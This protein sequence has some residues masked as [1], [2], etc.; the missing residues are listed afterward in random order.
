[1]IHKNANC[2]IHA[3]VLTCNQDDKHRVNNTTK[4]RPKKKRN[5]CYLFASDP[6][7]TI[8]SKE[9]RHV[10][11]LYDSI[12][13]I[14]GRQRKKR[15]MGHHVSKTRLGG[16]V[17]VSDRPT[18]HTWK[19]LDISCVYC[20]TIQYSTV[21]PFALSQFADYW[22]HVYPGASQEFELLI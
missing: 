19:S 1:M 6:K 5:S 22:L 16:K 11:S 21:P 9:I 10:V 17:W 8:Y 3:W 12:H 7:L 15:W 14:Q 2:I 13:M 18:I 4:L 20:C